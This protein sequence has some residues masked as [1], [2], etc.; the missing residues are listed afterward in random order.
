[1]KEPAEIGALRIIFPDFSFFFSETATVVVTLRIN[2]SGDSA[3][4]TAVNS[5]DQIYF[6]SLH[7]ALWDKSSVKH[8]LELLFINTHH[9]VLSVEGSFKK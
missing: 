8:R 3:A 7:I 2:H 1:L 6:T 4:Q 9:F 5:R